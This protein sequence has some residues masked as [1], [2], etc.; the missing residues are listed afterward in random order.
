M[1]WTF[2]VEVRS[3]Q[4]GPAWVPGLARLHI[5]RHLGGDHTYN[6][7]SVQSLPNSFHIGTL[8]TFVRHVGI[9]IIRQSFPL[10]V[11]VSMP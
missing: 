5:N 1:L 7:G 10:A 6:A 8:P 2:L 3:R 9:N 4:S 11:F